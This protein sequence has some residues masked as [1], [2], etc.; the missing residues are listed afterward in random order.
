M[1]P[2]TCSA[3]S[4][5]YWESC[6]MYMLLRR[7]WQES[8]PFEHFEH[9]FRHEFIVFFC[10]SAVG[11]N[12]CKCLFIVRTYKLLVFWKCF[13]GAVEFVYGVWCVVV[14]CLVVD[15]SLEREAVCE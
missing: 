3:I 13:F 11:E 14:I 12:L 15:Y 2:N 7:L 9:V 6:F 8:L 1:I 10:I 5:R 4:N